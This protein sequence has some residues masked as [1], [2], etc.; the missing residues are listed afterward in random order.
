MRDGTAL[1]RGTSSGTGQNDVTKELD[2]DLHFSFL[3]V[4]KNNV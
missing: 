1:A 3:K 4:L 2:A